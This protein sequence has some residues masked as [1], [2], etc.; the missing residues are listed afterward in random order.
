MN[1]R[2]GDLRNDKCS[3]EMD[4]RWKRVVLGEQNFWGLRWRS[5][6]PEFR[7]AITWPTL[8][9]WA[10]G[11]PRGSVRRG[12]FCVVPT[13]LVQNCKPGLPVAAACCTSDQRPRAVRRAA[14]AGFVF[15]FSAI[16]GLREFR[17]GMSRT[18]RSA[19]LD[20]AVPPSFRGLRRQRCFALTNLGSPGD[21]TGAAVTIWLRIR[22]ESCG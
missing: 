16:H 19:V 10:L 22:T 11:F 8:P 7:A 5:R 1:H 21:K 3:L 6:G 17:A 15:P 20:S 14:R 2:K 12:R 4:R 18:A 9:Q 13:A